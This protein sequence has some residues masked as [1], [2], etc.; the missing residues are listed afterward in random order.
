MRFAPTPGAMRPP[1]VPVAMLPAAWPY[2]LSL[3]LPASP[4][5]LSGPLV[6]QRRLASL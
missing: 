2:R 3:A 6:Q 5:S 1:A 4:R